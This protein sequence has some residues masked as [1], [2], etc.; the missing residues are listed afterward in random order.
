[1]KN[2]RTS[3][4]RTWHGVRMRRTDV[5]PDPD[6][7]PRTVTLPA[8]WDDSAAAA[9]AGLDTGTGPVILTVAAEAWIAPIA[10][11]ATEA[12][13]DIPLAD[14][15]HR[16]LLLR[17]GA[18][19]EAVWRGE[20]AEGPGFVLN[21]PAFLDTDGQLDVADIAEAV[22][23]AVIALSLAAPA[24]RDIDVGMADLAGLLAG[25]GIDY[26]SEAARDI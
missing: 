11:A 5:S 7:A 4:H 25:L 9:L 19:S 23:T 6:T 1:M 3:L 17:R 26:A 13:L 10:T 2:P 24:A 22:E 12:G 8:S 18:P 21:L 15:L 20:A 14:R 16:L